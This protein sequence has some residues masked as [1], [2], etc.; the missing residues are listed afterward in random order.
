MASISPSYKTVK[1]LL[2]SRSFGIDEYQREYK[3]DHQNIEELLTDFFNAFDRYYV[4]GDHASLVSEY[5]EYFLGS[6]IVTKR[7]NKHFLVDGQQRLT[8]LT[9]L[10]IYLYR[11][12]E[13]RGLGVAD[14]IRPLIYSD[15]FGEKKFNLDIAERVPVLRALFDGVAYNAD[16]DDESVKNILARYQDIEESGLADSL[17]D[18]LESF[19]YWFMSK[20]G[21]IEISTESDQQAYAIFETMNDRGK[22]LSPNDMLK[23]YLLSPI[24]DDADRRESNRRWREV[25]LQ[26]NTWGEEPNPERDAA[27]FKAW[28]RA[29]YASSSRERRA[30]ARDRDWELIGTTFH[31][32]FR[33]NAEKIGAGDAQKN[34]GIITK[35]IPFFAR[36][37]LKILEASASYTPGLESVYYNAQNN[38]TWQSTVLLAPLSIHDD[39]E[40]VRRKINATATYLD[41]WIMRRAVNYIRVTYST[42]NY[43][44]FTLARDIRGLPLDE[45]IHVLQQRLDEE[46]PKIGFDGSPSRGRGGLKDLQ[47]NQFSRR[48]IYHLLARVTSYVEVKSGK[49]DHFPH[50]VDRTA[51]N[52]MDIEHIWANDYSRYSAQFS[53]E[54]EFEDWRDNV[55]GLLLLPAD[56][57]RS[58]SDKPFEDKAKHYAKQNLWAASLTAHAYEHAPQFRKFVQDNN[59]P[60]KSYETF[61]RD[62][63][64]ERRDLLL[65]ICKQVWSSQRLTTV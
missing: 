59:L 3:W 32:W 5:G 8:S 4:E 30:D 52:S 61:G 50:L 22:P 27:F 44:M 55:A 16:G 40:T 42:A 54:G 12:T 13:S 49:P 51:K 57:N 7:G 41:I 36:A 46:E 34:I 10:L 24:I 14:T 6:I 39:D 29:Q 31:R 9:L 53:T 60:F 38:F 15:N 65:H 56:V 17:G 11:E 48:Y 45:L 43:T 20:V 33:D 25:V 63:Q 21:L 47:L 62:E 28:L 23:A 2:Q 64:M 18:G 19:A 1:D 37:Y 35:E 26:L 58:F